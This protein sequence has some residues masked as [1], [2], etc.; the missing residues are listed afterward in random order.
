MKLITADKLSRFFRNNQRRGQE[1]FPK[2]LK[3]LIYS[4]VTRA[5][6]IRIPTEDCIWASGVDGFVDIQESNDFH[7]PVG[8]SCWEFGTNQG[9]K[10]KADQDYQKRTYDDS[11]INKEEY[12]YIFCTPY[13]WDCKVSIEEW[14]KSKNDDGVWKE[15]KIYDA[16]IIE[17]WLE[18][19]L[20]VAIWLLKE[21]EEKLCE[22]SIKD[23]YDEY[24]RVTELTC[25]HISNGMLICS[26]ETLAKNFVERLKK[27]AQKTYII[28]TPTNIEYGYFFVIGSIQTFAD[29]ELKSK[30]LVVKSEAAFD[31]LKKH[32]KNVIFVLL[33]DYHGETYQKDNAYIT[34]TTENVYSDM[35]K[36]QYPLFYDFK[37]CLEDIGF[38]PSLAFEMTSKLNRNIS[39]F[40]RKY[41]SN[42][43]IKRPIW[44]E[45]K[46][47]RSIIPIAL[48]TTFDEE[49]DGD[50]EIISMLSGKSYEEYI[51]DLAEWKSSEDSPVSEYKGKYR[52]NSKEEALRV[53]DIQINSDKVKKLKEIFLKIF[54]CENSGEIIDCSIYEK[55]RYSKNIVI[56]ILDTF[57]ILFN[58]SSALDRDINEIF[59]SF[60]ENIAFLKQNCS[61]LPKLAEIA[62]SVFLDV[63]EMWIDNSNS[64]LKE[65][66]QGGD[67]WHACNT[68]LYIMESV[69]T[70]LRYAE[71][72]GQA[73]RIFIK[74]YYAAHNW[75]KTADKIK[76]ELSVF[77]SEHNGIVAMTLTERVRQFMELS[78]GEK[79]GIVKEIINDILDC[80]TR[81]FVIPQEFKWRKT[82]NPMVTVL[83]SEFYSVRNMMY[84]WLFK[85]DTDRLNVCMMAIRWIGY[86]SRSIN[87][88]IFS[89]ILSEL[90]ILDQKDSTKLHFFILEF[91]YNH[92]KYRS[93][94]NWEYV[95]EFIP[96]LLEIFKATEPTSLFDKYSYIFTYSWYRLPLLNPTPCKNGR[97]SNDE[98]RKMAMVDA[99]MGELSS[100]YGDELIDK[101]IKIVPDDYFP[102]F[103]LRKYFNNVK[104]ITERMLDANKINLLGYYIAQCSIDDI[105]ILLEQLQKEKLEKII[106][107][108]SI[109]TKII[110]YV[111]EHDLDNLY[112]ANRHVD[113]CQIKDMKLRDYIFEQ[114]LIYDPI[115]LLESVAWNSDSIEYDKVTSLL[116]ALLDKQFHL[117][118]SRRSQ[119]SLKEI[120]RRVD[121]KFYTEELSKLEIE[122]LPVYEEDA[123]SNYPLGLQR[124]L[125]DNPQEFIGL[126]DDI[127][128]NMDKDNSIERQIAFSIEGGLSMKCWIPADNIREFPDE[129]CR[130][131]YVVLESKR[132]QDEKYNNLIEYAL[133]GI[134]SFCPLFDEDEVW[135]P[136][137]A[138]DLLETISG[139]SRRNQKN[140]ANHFYV[141]LYNRRGMR[142]VG[143][144]TD[145]YRA[146]E[147]FDSFR[148]FYQNTHPTTALALE[149]IAKSYKQNSENDLDEAIMGF[150]EF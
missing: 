107:F 89:K 79:P 109:D 64:V 101:I 35:V 135:P 48:V 119:D 2:L 75:G 112:W 21:F 4:S 147:R 102:S 33:F 132:D 84:Q 134:L 126:M 76:K 144:G 37:K 29:E 124:F 60:G 114:M 133:T 143:D 59:N 69:K 80:R 54:S 123:L 19:H 90:K 34:I 18:T 14:Q 5:N 136:R 145:E 73:L 93:S 128:N 95:D 50:K 31:D 70:C 46:S 23:F 98:E 85:F 115:A 43:L 61:L 42:P 56:G 30:V 8:Y 116:R 20:D 111:H 28:Y 103:N 86:N 105:L 129:L 63:I 26:N 13:V 118:L 11:S 9:Y 52:I 12:T 17:D 91:I 106:K 120:I 108:F 113:L 140:I 74:F 41:A 117:C 127:A 1:V 3:K 83:P 110:K 10:T 66:F 39:C 65:C 125:F 53:L 7:V 87:E 47:K 49:Y 57:A 32:V 148:K 88:Q 99:F 24:K 25:P 55:S 72:C 92:R 16:V 100:Q 146:Y 78:K 58:G 45:D 122:F 22:D 15:V 6:Y 38:H 40:K 82:S 150:S 68:G 71:Y 130:W 131:I 138:A 67:F 104:Y 121:V 137:H 139:S 77:L 62:P 142:T 97:D 44:A 81:S 149:Y 94:E 96:K 36:L 51:D 27:D 141:L